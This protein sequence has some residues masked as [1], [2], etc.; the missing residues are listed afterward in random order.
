MEVPNLNP[1]EQPVVAPEPQAPVVDAE[2]DEWNEVGNEIFPDAKPV[3]KKEEAPVIEE[4]KEEAPVEPQAPDPVV[5]PQSETPPVPVAT[6]VEAPVVDAHQAQRQYVED[7]NVMKTEVKQV[8]FKDVQTELKDVD[9]D[10]IRSVEDV[11]KLVD[12]RTGQA[13]TEEA[14]AI[15]LVQA[16]QELSDRL[17]TMEK[18]V[19]QIASVN[20]AVKNQSDQINK[21][22]GE[23]L[24][25]KPELAKQLWDQYSGT[26]KMSPDGSIV[27]EAPV[28]LADFYSTALAPYAE[29]SK[30]QQEAEAAKKQ[31]EELSRKQ[32]QTDRSDIYGAGNIDTTDDETKEWTQVAKE[33]YS[34]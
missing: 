6:P 1:V 20:L 31:A 21:K 4:K 12:P 29:L 25:A 30:V 17:N 5:P 16:R 18:Q 32:Q 14:A 15:H 13:F 3:E 11:M 28:S 19:D 8:V 24:K 23:I 27:L 10:P 7:L 33:H 34:N 26:L 22:F 9:G 2:Q